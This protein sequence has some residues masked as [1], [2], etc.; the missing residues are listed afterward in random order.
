[1]D[2]ET[3]M[4]MRVEMATYGIPKDY[5]VQSVSTT[6]DYKLTKVGGKEYLLPVLVQV[7]ADQRYLLTRNVEA[8]KEYRKFGTETN[9]TFDTPETPAH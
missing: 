9:L 3:L 5:P 4:V 7:V 1:M 2:D 6:V 8:F